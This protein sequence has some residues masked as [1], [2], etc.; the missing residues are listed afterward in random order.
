MLEDKVERGGE[1]AP[2]MA[3]WAAP[4]RHGESDARRRIPPNRAAMV[5]S[6]LEIRARS[7]IPTT[8]QRGA[9]RLKARRTSWTGANKVNMADVL[10]SVILFPNTLARYSIK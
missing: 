8:F 10:P 3:P 4:P 9:L 5:S 1:G 6:G 7:S 2:P